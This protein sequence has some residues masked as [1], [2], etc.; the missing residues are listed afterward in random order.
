MWI[1]P[2]QMLKCKNI[3]NLFGC[4]DAQKVCGAEKCIYKMTLIWGERISKREMRIKERWRAAEAFWDDWDVPLLNVVVSFRCCGRSAVSFC[5]PWNSVLLSWDWLLV[6]LPITTTVFWFITT[7]PATQSHYTV[8]WSQNQLMLSCQ[9]LHSLGA[10][11]FLLTV[12]YMKT[13]T[14]KH[15]LN[16]K[17]F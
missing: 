15:M 12:K 4:H 16:T 5:S 8:A 9:P 6:G 7:S 1:N 11:L 13:N 17:I 2:K 10:S 3:N 14:T